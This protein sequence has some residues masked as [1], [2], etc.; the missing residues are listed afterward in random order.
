MKLRN[1]ED[2]KNVQ[3]V[4]RQGETTEFW[5]LIKEFVQERVDNITQQ[6]ESEETAQLPVAEYKT[7][8][9]ILKGR[10]KDLVGLLDLP[11]ELILQVE[12]PDQTQ[13]LLD[14]FPTEQDLAT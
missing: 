10:R 3:E 9:E 12:E 13:E 7:T 14:P 6:M 2:R 1:V 11:Q 4:L 8:M 5:A